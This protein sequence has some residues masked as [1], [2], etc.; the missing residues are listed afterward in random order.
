MQFLTSQALLNFLR[1]S[2]QTNLLLTIS[3]LLPFTPVSQNP[4]SQQ[5]AV[6]ATPLPSCT[7]FSFPWQ[8]L[9]PLH[10][11]ISFSYW[12][13]KGTVWDRLLLEK[14]VPRVTE[15]FSVRSSFQVLRSGA[16]RELSIQPSAE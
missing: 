8:M 12:R 7:A 1:T 9:N 16:R 6:D 14:E 13:I 15:P 4:A 2:S 10:S 11:S 3:H 5:L